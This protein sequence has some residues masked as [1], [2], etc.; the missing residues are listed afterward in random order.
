M[1]D[2]QVLKHLGGPEINS[3][4][5]SLVGQDGGNCAA[6]FDLIDI[7]DTL[8]VAIWNLAD[9]TWRYVRPNSP[10]HINEII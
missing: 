2:I 5:I 7:G 8:I 1:I 9:T 10:F 6:P 4:T 3:D